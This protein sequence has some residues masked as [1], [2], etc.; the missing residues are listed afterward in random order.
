MRTFTVA[1]GSFH[2]VQKAIN[3][4]KGYNNKIIIAAIISSVD[5]KWLCNNVS[6][7]DSIGDDIYHSIEVRYIIF[8]HALPCLGGCHGRR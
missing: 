4:N 6:M 8:L 1:L 7:W 3:L 5:Q 2:N